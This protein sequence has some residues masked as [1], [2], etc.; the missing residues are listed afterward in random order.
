MYI[1]LNKTFFIIYLCFQHRLH[2][3]FHNFLYYPLKKKKKTLD[4]NSTG[5]IKKK[6]IYITNELYYKH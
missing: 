5:R 6:I 4:L 3:N 2:N 1:F